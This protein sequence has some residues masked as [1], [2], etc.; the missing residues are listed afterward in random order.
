MSP[1]KDPVPTKAPAKIYKPHGPYPGSEEVPD[2]P[3]VAATGSSISVLLKA[4]DGESHKAGCGGSGEFGRLQV[5]YFS[6][7]LLI[8]RL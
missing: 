7:L 2:L 6:K 1:P 8:L 3:Q 5:F 4:L